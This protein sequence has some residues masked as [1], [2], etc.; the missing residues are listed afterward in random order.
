MRVLIS[1]LHGLPNRLRVG[2]GHEMATRYKLR[3]DGE[4]FTI[5]SGVLYRLG[6]C[7][8]GLVHDV[9]LVSSGKG[10]DIGFAARRNARATAQLRRK[11]KKT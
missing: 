2:N 6:C 7:D 3:N 8:C 10:K 5:P 4:G 11:M 1:T 9:V